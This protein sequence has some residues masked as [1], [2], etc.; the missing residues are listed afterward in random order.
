MKQKSLWLKKRRVHY[1]ECVL[2]EAQCV[3]HK[4]LAKL[5]KNVDLACLTDI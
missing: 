3:F 2:S 1:C 4:R 5:S